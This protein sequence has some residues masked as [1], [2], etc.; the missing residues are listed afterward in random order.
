MSPGDRLSCGS[1]LT[2]GLGSGVLMFRVDDGR[3]LRAVVEHDLEHAIAQN[4]RR[5]GTHAGDSGYFMQ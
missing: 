1:T 2:T 3:Y 5:Y 4:P